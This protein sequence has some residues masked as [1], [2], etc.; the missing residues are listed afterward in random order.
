MNER[1]NPL[2]TATL[3]PRGPGYADLAQIFPDGAIPLLSPAPAER[4]GPHGRMSFYQVDPSQCSPEQLRKAAE[5]IARNF[6][7]EAEQ[8]L[9]DLRGPHG[10]PVREENV[11]VGFSMRAFI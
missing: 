5:I 8:V 6:H 4:D 10:W 1:R 9:E 3:N 2:W 11:T 7:V